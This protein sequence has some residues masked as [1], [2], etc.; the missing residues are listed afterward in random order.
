MNS[1]LC[2]DQNTRSVRVEEELCREMA[3]AVLWSQPAV[4]IGSG[5]GCIEGVCVSWGTGMS[6]A[7]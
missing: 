2:Q 4:G 7:A 6:Y 1:V 5:V 3:V